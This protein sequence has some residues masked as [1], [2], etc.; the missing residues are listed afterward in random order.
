VVP[1]N[2]EELVEQWTAAHGVSMTPARSERNGPL[3]R[4][5]YADGAG[6]VK[7]ES[8]V[9]EGLAHAFPIQ[10]AGEPACGQPGDFVVAAGVCAAREIARFWGVATD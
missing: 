7:V 2:R 1:R 3:A 10:T 8:V 4:E 6:I 9:I 5:V